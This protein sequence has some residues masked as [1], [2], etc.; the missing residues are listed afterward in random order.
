MPVYVLHEFLTTEAPGFFLTRD[1]TDA[2]ARSIF[3]SDPAIFRLNRLEVRTDATGR[4]ISETILA[5]RE[6]TND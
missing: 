3:D 5:E 4:H 2:G 1:L 6:N